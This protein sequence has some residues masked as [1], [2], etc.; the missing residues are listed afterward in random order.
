MP[1]QRQSSRLLASNWTPGK[2]TLLNALGLGK[3]KVS[4]PKFRPTLTESLVAQSGANPPQTQAALLSGATAPL[5]SAG[6]NT[7]GTSKPP[8]IAGASTAGGIFNKAALE[9]IWIQA[10]GNPAK[11]DIASAVALAES[12]GNPNAISPTQDYGLWQINRAA[13]PTQFTL[14]P[15]ANARAAVAI[16]SNGTNWTPWVTFNS[17]AYRKFL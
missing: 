11:A 4:Y 5:S 15:L 1:A 9:A 2:V 7:G 10:G 14:N 3:W 13:H 16:S 12:S 6:G 17:G 8:N